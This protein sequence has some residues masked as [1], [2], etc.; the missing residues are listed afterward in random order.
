MTESEYDGTVE[1][2]QGM[3]ATTFTETHNQE[4]Y[5]RTLEVLPQFTTHWAEFL[6][7]CVS[8]LNAEGL[9]LARHWVNNK[10]VKGITVYEPPMSWKG[11]PMKLNP[12]GG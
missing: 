7:G 10:Q 6:P 1:M 4:K 12:I 8:Y 3:V 2:E 5:N 11:K 9:E